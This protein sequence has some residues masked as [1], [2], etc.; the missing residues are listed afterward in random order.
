MRLDKETAVKEIK[1]FLI[2]PTG[3]ADVYLRRY[4]SDPASKCNSS[5]GY[6]N[7]RSGFVMR[8]PFPIENGLAGDGTLEHDHADQRWPHYC[9]CGYAFKDSDPWQVNAERLYRRTDTGEVMNLVDM[10]AGAMWDAFWLHGFWTG[11]DGK[12]IAVRL[13]GGFDWYMD[14]PANNSGTPWQRSGTMPKITA[15]PSILVTGTNGYHGWLTDGVL[16]EC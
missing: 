7:A 14:S 11:P 10:P 9:A 15:R 4:V 8:I 2:E 16:T 1:C 5:H 6:H 13:P 12:S 3:E